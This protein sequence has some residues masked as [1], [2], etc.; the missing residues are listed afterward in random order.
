[1]ILSPNPPRPAAAKKIVV[2][3]DDS[4]MLDMIATALRSAGYEVIPF[5]EPLEALDWLSHAQWGVD[6]IVTD[7]MMPGTNGLA[8][9]KT[10]RAKAGP[11]AILLISACLS[12]EALWGD[13]QED[14]PFLAK[15]F[16][17]PALFEAVERAIARHPRNP[18]GSS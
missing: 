4:A 14:L 18:S 15:P 3:E 9:A 8:L 13:G 11:I 7:I 17:L 6:L 2:V 5:T 12:D 1:V 16:S 10:I